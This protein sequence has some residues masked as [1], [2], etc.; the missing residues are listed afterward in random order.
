MVA[1]LEEHRCLQ[2]QEHE[3]QYGRV[4]ADECWFAIAIHFKMLM[5]KAV[6]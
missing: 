1:V 4:H 5:K 2:D 3:N 6:K